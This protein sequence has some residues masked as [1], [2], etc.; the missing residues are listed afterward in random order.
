MR[1]YAIAPVGCPDCTSHL[2]RYPVADN[3]AILVFEDREH[4]EVALR[5]ANA[6]GVEHEIVEFVRWISS[7]D[8]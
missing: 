8:P 5:D 6:F 1:L 3:L 7:S 2:T 4:A